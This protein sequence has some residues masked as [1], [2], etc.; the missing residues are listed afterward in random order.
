MAYLRCHP[1][2]F[3]HNKQNHPNW[4]LIKSKENQNALMGFQGEEVWAIKIAELGEEMKRVLRKCEERM[5]KGM[6]M[7]E[8]R[9]EMGG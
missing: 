6:K 4:G 5:K 8:Q 7:D 3:S 1:T 2:P 9:D